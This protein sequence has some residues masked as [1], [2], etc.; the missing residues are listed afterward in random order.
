VGV[1][2][3]GRLLHIDR[4]SVKV[5]VAEWYVGK[6]I[7]V[8]GLASMIEVETDNHISSSMNNTDYNTDYNL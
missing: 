4:S 6:W 2:E 1:V 8:S 7:P 5:V 3:N